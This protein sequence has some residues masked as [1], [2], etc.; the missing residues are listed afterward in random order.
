MVQEKEKL[1]KAEL[2]EHQKAKILQTQPENLSVTQKSKEQKPPDAPPE[3]DFDIADFELRLHPPGPG[4][5]PPSPGENTTEARFV[6]FSHDMYAYLRPNHKVPVV[7]NFI[8]GHAD[9]SAGVPSADV[10]QLKVGDYVIFREGSD[11]DL[12][13]DLADR[14]LARAG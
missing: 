9:E 7:T 14:G 13:R 12:L 2:T 8:A 4:P 5:R 3:T 1:K 11:S 6:D 10:S